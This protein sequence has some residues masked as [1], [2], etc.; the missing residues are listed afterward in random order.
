MSATMEVT[1]R[2][3]Y[4]I[5]HIA[6]SIDNI[7]DLKTLQTIIR[8][9]LVSSDEICSELSNWIELSENL[10][11]Q[12]YDTEK[13][14]FCKIDSI[15]LHHHS[16]YMNLNPAERT[17]QLS[18]EY[19]NLKNKKDQARYYVHRT[20]NSSEIAECIISR[21]S[22]VAS[23]DRGALTKFDERITELIYFIDDVSGSR[24][25]GEST[26][27]DVEIN[28]CELDEFFD[29]LK[30]S[31]NQIQNSLNETVEYFRL[32]CIH[33]NRAI[34]FQQQVENIGADI[35]SKYQL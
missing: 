34:D 20:I 23:F 4:A 10:F 1:S 30:Q 31:I 27:W 24:S 25:S 15:F 22:M 11:Q 6:G 13:N 7:T 28:G 12:I 29:Y 8:E 14:T 21:A 19:T 17:S 5:Q 33:H 18:E 2:E 3:N 35:F 16:K 26:L 9:L 32:A